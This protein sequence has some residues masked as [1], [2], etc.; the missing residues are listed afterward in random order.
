MS[1]A[2]ESDK[3]VGEIGPGTSFVVAYLAAKH[4]FVRY[5]IIRQLQASLNMSNHQKTF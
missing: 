3:K 5:F 1:S 2:K 4:V